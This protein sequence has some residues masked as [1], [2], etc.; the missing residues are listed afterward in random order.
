VP[1]L[2]SRTNVGT[3][4][5]YDYSTASSV[6]TVTKGYMERGNNRVN[7]Y[8]GGSWCLGGQFQNSQYGKRSGSK[9]FLNGVALSCDTFANFTYNE[10]SEI[11]ISNKAA[12]TVRNAQNYFFTL[13]AARPY[14]TNNVV[15]IMDGSSFSVSRFYT[16]SG[17]SSS[18]WHNTIVV[19]GAGSRLETRDG[20][21]PL[22]FGYKH[23]GTE[24]R[25]ED[26]GWLGGLQMR[27]GCESGVGNNVLVI[28]GEGSVISNKKSGAI[29]YAAGADSNRVEVL[30]GGKYLCNPA[31]EY[32][33]IDLGASGSSYNTFVLSN[34]TLRCRRLSVSPS[35]ESHHNRFVISGTTSAYE[36]Y[37]N[38][39][40]PLF[41]KGY[42]SEVVVENNAVFSKGTTA[43]S[44][45]SGSGATEGGGSNNT[46]IV[47]NNSVCTLTKLTVGDGKAD[48]EN[49]GVIVDRDS[50]LTV[51]GDF[52]MKAKSSR[53]FIGAGSTLS[54]AGWVTLR[55][56][57][58]EYVLSN[59]TVKV[60][61]AGAS[62]R[63]IVG[64]G[65]ADYQGTNSTLVLKGDSPCLTSNDASKDIILIFTSGTN[66]GL[67]FELP[68]E[69]YAQAPLR[70]ITQMQHGND[71]RIDI[72]GIEAF[73]RSLT[74]KVEVP[75]ID[76]TT[77]SGLMWLTDP[78][79]G[80]AA[81][82]AANAKLP[83]GCELKVVRSGG[84]DYLK[85]SVRAIYA[86]T[87][88]IFR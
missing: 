23:G 60:N 78:A 33:T 17:S 20:T 74:K 68:P 83:R 15:R 54:C 57:D 46:F 38:E 3:P 25:I 71:L 56:S 43:F 28:A 8:R 76:T 13:D 26:G 11:V 14:V 9:S 59:G 73:Q 18:P 84:K 55:T 7:E 86:G 24:V 63:L 81:L 48:F 69:G 77:S 32:A 70:G 6:F 79:R 30:A 10:N 61:N 37:T 80:A 50:T 12:V 45:Q 36:L 72:T 22:R 87:L 40:W 52:T 29:G 5:L 88:L 62:G 16:D 66:P 64:S 2:R 51:G 39:I 82:T 85:L 58:S 47:R 65:E 67:R 19:S 41:G 31:S 53:L 27:M 49:A 1:F 4:T 21:E 35:A 42:D 44:S 75:L 34:G